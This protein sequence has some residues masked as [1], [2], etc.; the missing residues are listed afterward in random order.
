MLHQE[1]TDAVAAGKFHIYPI[2]NIEEGLALLSG[3]AV[4]ELQA[5]GKYPEGTINQRV[6]ARLTEFARAAEPVASNKNVTGNSQ[7]E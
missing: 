3:Q 2:S 1:V 7:E 4:G 6:I 5:D